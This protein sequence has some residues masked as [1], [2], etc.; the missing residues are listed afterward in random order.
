MQ[1]HS[2]LEVLSNSLSHAAFVM[3]VAGRLDTAESLGFDRQ[4]IRDLIKREMIQLAAFI[5]LVVNRLHEIQNDAIA[6]ERLC[7]GGETECS[8]RQK[9]TKP[10]T[11]SKNEK[12]MS[13]EQKN[14]AT[15]T[16]DEAGQEQLTFDWT[17]PNPG[18]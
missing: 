14:E 17:R 13:D 4:K 2:P 9:F 12:P 16:K 7:G 1:L 18:A 3:E 8:G 15:N 6:T 10:K 5:G 11:T